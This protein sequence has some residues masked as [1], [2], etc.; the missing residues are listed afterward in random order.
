M[1]EDAPAGRGRVASR[2][3]TTRRAWPCSPRRRPLVAR[4]VDNRRRRVHHRAALRPPRR[5]PRLGCRPAPILP[6]RT[7]RAAAGRPASSAA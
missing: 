7:R 2:R 4:A 3:S 5:W 6:G 1:I